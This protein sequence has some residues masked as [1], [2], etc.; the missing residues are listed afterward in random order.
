[1]TRQLQGSRAARPELATAGFTLVLLTTMLLCGCPKQGGAGEYDGT[2]TPPVNVPALLPSGE[3][4]PLAHI[5]NSP[6]D[7]VGMPEEGAEGAGT[8][9][10]PGGPP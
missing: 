9:G 1:M 8:P 4:N 6:E 3:P 5:P 7:A 2:V 10:M